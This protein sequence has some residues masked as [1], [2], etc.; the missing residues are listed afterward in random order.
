VVL[1]NTEI[2]RHV[3]EMDADASFAQEIALHM[4]LL[5]AISQSHPNILAL[6]SQ[7]LFAFS[8]FQHSQLSPDLTTITSLLLGYLLYTSSLACHDLLLDE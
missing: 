6:Q 8:P 2:Y 1:K 4:L 3:D 7:I 5:S